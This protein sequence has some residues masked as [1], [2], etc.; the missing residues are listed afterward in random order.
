MNLKSL[1]LKAKVPINLVLIGISI[2]PILDK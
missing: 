1:E 2:D